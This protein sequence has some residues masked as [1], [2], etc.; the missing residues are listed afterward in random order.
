[1]F[2]GEY[3]QMGDEKI[4]GEALLPNAHMH[5]KCSRAHDPRTRQAVSTAIELTSQKHQSGGG[6]GQIQTHINP[7]ANALIMPL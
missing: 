4:V 5:I 1:M 6:G 2:Y 7:L 3:T